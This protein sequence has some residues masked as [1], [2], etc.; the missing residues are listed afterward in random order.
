MSGSKKS[1]GMEPTW[2]KLESGQRAVTEL[3]SPA[4]GSLSPYGDTPLPMRRIPYQH[5]TTVVNR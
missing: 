2:P 1:K 3:V 4:Q 5:P